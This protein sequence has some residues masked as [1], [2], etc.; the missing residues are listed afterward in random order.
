[1]QDG[2]A[3]ITIPDYKYVFKDNG[4][5]IYA[6]LKEGQY[7]KIYKI[8]TESSITWYA[9]QYDPNIIPK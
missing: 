7:Y 3:Y 6:P 9:E 4:K 8:S 1:V 5:L 2:K